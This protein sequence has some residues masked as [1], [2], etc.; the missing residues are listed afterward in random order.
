MRHRRHWIKHSISVLFI[1][2]L[3]SGL[4]GCGGGGDAQPAG[5]EGGVE[6]TITISGAWALYPLMVRWGEE[7]QK[8]YPDV[9]LDISAGGAGKGLADALAGAVDIGMVSREI[10]PE[11]EAKGAFWTAVVKDAVFPTISAANPVWDDLQQKGLSREVFQGIF[12]SGE[13]TTWGQ[14]IGRPEVS[15][16]IHVFTR[17]DACGAAETWAKYLGAQQEDLLGIAVYGDPGLL[18]AVIKDPLAIGF[19]N[20]NYAYDVDT[21]LPV[22]GARVAPID[23]NDNG[24]ADVDEIYLTKEQAVNAVAT[25]KYPSPPARDLNLVTRGQPDGLTAA[26]ISWILTDGQAFVDEA[27]YIALPAERLATEADKLGD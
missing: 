7:F 21:G 14:A 25:N 11:E 16:P 19:N 17:S 6:G 4:V 15:D 2:A 1:V 5:A 27:G 23:A 9:R 8:V 3:L 22:E 10:S 24:Q 13:I 26:F 20:L 12:I 18:D